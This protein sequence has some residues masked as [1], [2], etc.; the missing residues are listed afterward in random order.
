ML[1]PLDPPVLA[2]IASYLE[3]SDSVENFL[4]ACKASASLRLDGYALALWIRRYYGPKALAA[5]AQSP[6]A[7]RL[8]PAG[9]Q[10]AIG[11]LLEEEGEGQLA[12]LGA[13]SSILSVL[14]RRGE[15]E[16]IRNL[17]NRLNPAD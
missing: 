2:I 3:S 7:L 5:L 17:L 4:S 12:D 1:F 6:A 8:S 10:T 9:M 13:M 14:I 16:M 15:A 11:A